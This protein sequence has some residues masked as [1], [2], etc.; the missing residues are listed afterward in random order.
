[1]LV[2]NNALAPD[3]VDFWVNTNANWGCDAT[4][5]AMPPAVCSMVGFGG[6]SMVPGTAAM[7]DRDGAE[8]LFQAEQRIMNATL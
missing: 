6:F 8:P 3:S 7:F 1:M 5:K 2:S 4:G